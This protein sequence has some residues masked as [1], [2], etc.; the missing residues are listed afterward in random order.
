MLFTAPPICIFN[1]DCVVALG[2]LVDHCSTNRSNIKDKRVSVESIT[3]DEV[4]QVC[5]FS[6]SE[7][8]SKQT[9]T[10]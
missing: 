1:V 2:F 8:Q 3:N 4:G 9:K 5:H 6:I 7:K 10:I